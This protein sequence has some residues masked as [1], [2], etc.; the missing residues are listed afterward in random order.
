MSRKTNTQISNPLT[1]IDIDHTNSNHQ[2]I[3]LS[4]IIVNYN[5][6]EFLEQALISVKKA[7][8]GISSEIIV[9]DNASRDGS[10]QL[11]QQRYPDVHLLVN[12]KNLGFAKASNQGLRKAKGKYLALLNPDTIVQEDT[13]STM[14]DFSKKHPDTGM[15]GCKILNPDGTLQLACRRS[16][17][18]PWV[19][20]TKMIGL[21]HLFPK[22]KIFGKYNLSY[23]DSNLTYEVEAISGSFM[24]IQRKILEEVGYLDESF[25]LY[26][27]DLDWCYRIREKGWKVRYFSGTQII[28]FKGECSKRSQFDNLKVF[29]QAMAL[30]VQ[31]HFKRK[32][33]LI[34]YWL[35][36]VAIWLRAGFSFLKKIIVTLSVPITDLILLTLSLILAIYIRFESFARLRSFIPV[37]I[38][39]SLIWMATL[40]LFGCYHKHK[41]SSSKAGSAILVGFL[42]NASLTYFFKQYAFS[43]LVVLLASVL[44]LIVIPGWRLVIKLLP[45]LSLM[46]FKGTLGKTLLG[47]KTVIVGDFTSGEKLL[48]KFNSQIDAGYRIA[49]L[50]SINGKDQGQTYHS[51]KV[52]GTIEDL[53]SI[54]CEEKIQEVIFSTNRLSYDQIL[55]IISRSKKQRVNFK[56]VPS[57]LEVIIG[58]ASIERMDDMPLLEIEYKLYQSRHRFIK[59]VFDAVLAISGLILSIPIFLYK[60][61]LTS[62]KIKKRIVYGEQNRTI[63]L[64]EFADNSP[65]FIKRIPYLWSILKGD[66]SLVGREIVEVE[67]NSKFSPQMEMYLKPGL[68]G[69][70]QVNSHRPLTQ[71]EK[72]KY[73]LYY[74]KNYSP[75]L[76]LEIIFK[77]LF[78]I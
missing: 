32:Y 48:E 60:R 43:R 47:R 28:H 69:L 61:F 17:P 26:G 77:A 72:E 40:S 58:K 30:F 57:N 39:Y 18:T 68:T 8:R 73:H 10:A 1:R 55:G 67:E 64:Y 44:S 15:L 42:F 37:D 41:F 50:V 19:A 76:D 4:V 11:I 65:N 35:L 56:L 25:F 78:K 33:L 51:L 6:K 59:R 63:A 54:I 75:L 22:S 2:E 5:V 14:L 21:S 31:K 49:G 12:S 45:R 46:P 7:L 16:Y 71:A 23:L 62:V 24:M 70:V 74:M 66:L 36:L 34:P 27:E 29:Y 9:V 52:L 38:A 3:E 53:D 13:F 20:F